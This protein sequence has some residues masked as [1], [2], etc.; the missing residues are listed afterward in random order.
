MQK[1]SSSTATANSAG[2][3]TQGQPGSGIDA[4]M[5]TVAWLNAIQR[6]LVN[7]VVGSGQTLTPNDDGQVLKAVKMLQELAST[8]DKVTG[9]PTTRD[10]Y[11]LS[12]VFTKTETGTAIQDAVAAIVASSPAALDTLKEL[13]DALGNDP[14]FATTITNALAG[15]A[16]KATTI[17]GYGITDALVVGAGG[18]LSAP[19]VVAGAIAAI[20]SS[21]LYSA[22]SPNT[23]DTPSSYPNTVGMHM[24]FSN[25]S[26]GADIAVSLNDNIGNLLFRNLGPNASG[27]RKVWH[28]GNFTLSSKISGTACS[29]AGFASSSVG[30]PFM[31]HTDGTVVRLQVDRP[32]DTASFAPNGFSKNADT[33]EIT[34][35]MEVAIGDIPAGGRT[36]DIT[37]PFAFPNAFVHVTSIVFRSADATVRHISNG[38]YSMG[39]LNGCRLQIDEAAQTVQPSSLTA[40]VTAIGN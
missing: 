27:W 25:T 15:K 31:R 16:N 22:V 38:Y 34:Q 2:E 6:E 18:W 12:D 20:P 32:K 5:I 39:T 35:R 37:W 30:A 17:A 14:N 9:K 21:R 13:A 19:A 7:L 40:I 1:I 4:T 11:K 29:E 26:F 28:D 23:T 8:W 36:I 3:F 10:G 33:G 24:I